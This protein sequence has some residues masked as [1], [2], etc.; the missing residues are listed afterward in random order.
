MKTFS[1]VIIKVKSKYDFNKPLG[2]MAKP[3]IIKALIEP[4]KA[5]DDVKE[6]L[7]ECI[8]LND[9]LEVMSNTTNELITPRTE[10]QIHEFITQV[11][12]LA[13]LAR[14]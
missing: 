3:A 5:R 4:L 2:I 7:K 9:I 6:M 14:L 13:K 10:D 1:D 8:T 12:R 11:D